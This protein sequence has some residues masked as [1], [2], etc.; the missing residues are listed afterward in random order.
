MIFDS[1]NADTIQKIVI[2]TKG[3]GGPSMLSADDWSNMLVSQQYGTEGTDL[4]KTIARL[5][6]LLCVEK[7]A[8]PNSL[9]ALLEC[10]LIPLDLNPG[11]LPIGN[12][13]VL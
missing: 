12:W 2:R 5:A 3:A 13:D 4:C 6:R 8:Y 11:F 7:F 1:I 9:S 10:R